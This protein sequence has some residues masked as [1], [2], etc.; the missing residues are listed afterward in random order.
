[1]I[2]WAVSVAAIVVAIVAWAQGNDWE[3]SGLSI[4]QA[5][6]LFGLLAFSLMW[7]HYI[8]SVARQYFKIGKTV[9]YSYFEITSVLVLV[10]ILIHPGLLAWQLWR[11]GAG[12]PPGSYF[13]FVGPQLKIAILAGITGLLVFLAYEFRR[14]FANHAWWAYVQA[15]SDAAML[16]IFIHAL[17]LGG[18][19]QQGWFRRVWFFYGITLIGSLFYT[20]ILKFRQRTI[21]K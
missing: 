11:D 14:R 12:L 3:F 1:M 21:A 13:N 18:Q 2:A 10:A 5:F 8:A 7:S 16:L 19:L 20:Y 9:L 4:Y 6:P 17:R 15:A